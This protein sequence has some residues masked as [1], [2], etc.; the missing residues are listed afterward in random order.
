MQHL[1]Y[2]VMTELVKGVE[3]IHKSFRK[4]EPKATLGAHLR[5]NDRRE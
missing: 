2:L 4:F 5:S 3:R 1:R